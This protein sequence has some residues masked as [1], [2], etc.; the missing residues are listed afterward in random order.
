[1]QNIEELEGGK[2]ALRITI[3]TYWRPSGKDIHKRRNAKDSDDWGVRP[4]PDLEVI[5][6]RDLYEKSVRT[7]RLRDVTPV[8]EL[9]VKRTASSPAAAKEAPGN[10][11]T[12]SP[13]KP[14]EPTTQ[15]PIPVPDAGEDEPVDLFYVD[16]QL[17]KAI[18]VL[19][20]RLKRSGSSL[21]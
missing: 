13:V 16:P 6:G 11:A 19:E 7:R 4:D 3:A 10:A 15:P 20:Q 5:L 12:P 2:S 14:G 9:E 8:A 17:Q 18:D 1:V 21:H